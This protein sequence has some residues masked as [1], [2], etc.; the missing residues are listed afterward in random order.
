MVPLSALGHYTAAAPAAERP[1]AELD[2]TILGGLV[3]SFSRAMTSLRDA[4]LALDEI[5]V[6]NDIPHIEYSGLAHKGA[7]H[8]FH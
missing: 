2:Q 7:F 6:L 4:D 8:E 3:R 5:A 1:R